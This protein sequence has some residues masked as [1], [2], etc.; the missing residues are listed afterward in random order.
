MGE[1]VAL[2]QAL[3]QD[4]EV[5]IVVPHVKTLGGEDVGVPTEDYG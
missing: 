3:P 4:V 1:E 2:Y 5:H